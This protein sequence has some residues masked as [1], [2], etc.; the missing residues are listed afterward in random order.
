MECLGRPIS[1][2]SPGS[3]RRRGHARLHRI[4]IARD[5][6]SAQNHMKRCTE[7][8]QDR[9]L[10]IRRS[11]AFFPQQAPRQPRAC[12]C[13][14]AMAGPQPVPYPPIQS[15][16]RTPLHYAEVKAK[17]WGKNLPVIAHAGALPTESG[18]PATTLRNSRRD[19]C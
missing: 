4:R 14:G 16:K 1:H 5:L 3:H 10:N 15:S 11:P 12:P 7:S 13:G 8:D 19:A 6:R 9:S 2:R 18:G 17:Q